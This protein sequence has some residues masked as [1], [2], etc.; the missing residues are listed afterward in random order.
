[1]SNTNTE[2][3]PKLV[4]YVISPVVMF[5][6]SSEYSANFSLSAGLAAVVRVAA[7]TSRW[8]VG[9]L[10]LYLSDLLGRLQWTFE[11]G[12]WALHHRRHPVW[13][14]CHPQFVKF[15]SALCRQHS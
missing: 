14:F 15:K 3:I 9:G 4:I 13:V 5:Y 6:L 10:S 2:T 12:R 11:V 1:M 7:H 8:K